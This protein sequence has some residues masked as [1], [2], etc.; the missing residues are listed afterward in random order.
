MNSTPYIRRHSRWFE[1]ILLSYFFQFITGGIVLVVSCAIPIWGYAFWNSNDPNLITSLSASLIAFS[2]ST[3]SLRKLFRLPGSE[4]VSYILPVALICYAVPIGLILFFRT[5]YSIQIFLVG[6]FV[7]LIWCFAGFFLGRRYR[8]IR[9]AILPF[10]SIS[11]LE[12]SHGAL[13]KTLSTPGLEGQRYNAIV[14]DFNSPMITAEW[15]KFLAQCTL[16][17]IPVYSE[18]KI[19]EFLTGRVKINRLSENIFGSLLPSEFYEYIKR[20]IDI[21]SAVLLIP[22]FSPIFILIAIL[23]KIESKGPALFIQPRMGFRG[24]VF[25]MLKFRSMYIDKKGSGFTN[26]EDDPRITKI[27]KFIRKYR[28]DE[29]PQI[30]NI[31]IGQ[32]SF[33][34]PRPESFELSQWYEKDVPFFAYRHVVRPGI[35]GWAQVEQGYAAEVEGMNVKLEYDFY[36]IKNFSFWLDLLITFKTIK[37][38]LTG[39]GSR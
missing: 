13:F 25:P 1:R 23:I 5:T 21:F 17:R 36:Y 31:L 7:T 22:F 33:I 19:R 18:K 20:L 2:I 14:A 26:P 28:I 27:G 3:F 15:E 16:A 35:S 4:S 9:Y 37:T 30:F 34:G 11:E 12:L 24:K 29:L 6:F 32:M 39:F 10:G 8:L 38:I